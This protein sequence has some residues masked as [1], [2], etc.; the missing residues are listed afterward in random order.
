M[1]KQYSN[2]ISQALLFLTLYLLPETFFILYFSL[3][4][5]PLYSSSKSAVASTSSASSNSCGCLTNSTWMTRKVTI[6]STKRNKSTIFLALFVEGN[7][8]SVWL[9]SIY[10]FIFIYNYQLN[11]LK[12]AFIYFHFFTIL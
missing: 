3:P 10:C 4:P 7:T 12:Q 6:A 1:S 2:S 11:K 9:R 5:L 8:Y